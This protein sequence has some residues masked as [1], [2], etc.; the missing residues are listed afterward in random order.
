[1]RSIFKGLLAVAVLFVVM[2]I[3]AMTA[4]PV[5]AD[6]GDVDN[7]WIY[8]LPSEVSTTSTTYERLL[9]VGLSYVPDPTD[10]NFNYELRVS[11]NAGTAYV[12]V[13]RNGATLGGP[14][15][16]NEKETNNTN[17]DL[18]PGVNGYYRDDS[19]AVNRTGWYYD[20]QLLTFEL[21]GKVSAGAEM[22]IRRVRI[23]IYDSTPLTFENNFD[24]GDTPDAGTGTEDD[25]FIIEN[26]YIDAEIEGGDG[27]TIKDV[28][29][30]YWIIRNSRI[31]NTCDSENAGIYLEN[32]ANGVIQ[33]N[34]IDNCYYA[35]QVENC[36]NIT[37]FGNMLSNSQGYG[38]HL[39][40][41]ESIASYYN[42]FE[43]S[44]IRHAYDN[45]AN[46]WDSGS[47]GNYWDD[48]QPPTY[49]EIGSTGII[50]MPR[51]IFG[52]FGVDGYP[53]VMAEGA[54]GVVVSISPAV[55]SGVVGDTVSFTV[56]VQ[57]LSTETTIYDLAVTDVEGWTTSLQSTITVWP[58]STES[59]AMNVV[60]S[61]ATAVGASNTVTVTVTD[62][63][64]SAITTSSN[65]IVVVTITPDVGIASWAANL[66]V[67]LGISEDS[68]GILM[69]A[70]LLMAFL[71]PMGYIGFP[72]EGMIAF[73][74]VLVGLTTALGWMPVWIA[75]MVGIG[76]ALILAR[77]LS[78]W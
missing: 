59:A 5:A 27:I 33:S 53:L 12:Q 66:A 76:F 19:H 52:G 23:E 29:N 43:N 13:Y 51:T 36:E 37:V 20:N 78:N 39:K 15:S 75:L 61:S 38:M 67:G 40:G 55:Q 7:G 41:C 73:I 64:D 77:Q 22:S 58:Y 3:G 44:G 4:D 17:Y 69:S 32:V 9:L 72:M 56:S 1:M 2:M 54:Y 45:A 71:I 21:W 48:W 31:V 57:N 46:D 8:L 62:Q 63:S 35:I 70:M 47:H 16:G 74:I 25:P 10:L 11:E 14:G 42:Y 60:I 34:I 65:C 49:P 50:S 18:Y 24:D 68:A 26:V 28:D 6:N 30:S